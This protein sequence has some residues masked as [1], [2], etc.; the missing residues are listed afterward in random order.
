LLPNPSHLIPTNPI[1][2][3]QQSAPGEGQ[4]HE[5]NKA[6]HIFE[7]P[8]KRRAAASAEIGTISEISEVSDPLLRYR[9]SH[10]LARACFT[11]INSKEN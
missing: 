10:F 6:K 5:P 1:A 9:I 4:G 11:I 7:T 2:S 3:R 8:I